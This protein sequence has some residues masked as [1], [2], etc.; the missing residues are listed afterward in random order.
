MPNAMNYRN[1]PRSLA[2]TLILGLLGALSLCQTGCTQKAQDKASSQVPAISGLTFEDLATPTTAWVSKGGASAWTMTANASTT[3]LMANFGTTGGGAVLSPGN[4][5]IVSGVPVHVAPATTTTYTLT[6]TDAAG[7]TATQ[8]AILTVVPSPNATIT[9][10]ATAIANTA[11]LAASVSSD[12]AVNAPGTTYQ[13]AALGNCVI[14]SD[15]TSPAITFTAGSANAD[16]SAQNLQLQCKVTNPA[17]TPVVDTQ[18]VTIPVNAV[19][20]ASLSYPSATLTFYQG[21]AIQ[22]QSPTVTGAVQTYKVSPALPA[23]LILDPALGTLTG[24][25]TTVTPAANY[26]VTATNSGGSTTAVLNI[27]V[28]AQPAIVFNTPTPAKIGPGDTSIL[29]WTSGSN[30]S[31][32]SIVGNPVDATLPATFPIT[33]SANVSPAQTTTY[34]LTATLVGGGTLSGGTQTVTVDKTPLAFTTQLSATSGVVAYGGTSTLNWVLTGTPDVFTLTS[35]ATAGSVSLLGSTSYTAFPLRRQNYT[36][37]ASNKVPSSAT[38]GPVMVA[39]Q[40]LDTLAGNITLG[41]GSHDGTGTAAQFNAPYN[42]ARDPA[43]NIYVPD[44]NNHIIRVVTPQGAVSTLAG[45]CGVP[46]VTD[47]VSGLQAQFKGPHA[48]A[49]WV[50]PS[51]SQPYL[52]VV[53]YTNNSIRKITLNTGTTP[54]TATNVSLFAGTMGSYGTSGNFFD[55]PSGILI[56]SSNNMYVSEQY[57][58]DVLKITGLSGAQGNTYLQNGG[59]LT[60]Y[61]GSRGNDGYVDGPNASAYFYQISSMVMDS[62]NNIYVAESKANRIRMISPT[63]TSTLAGDTAQLGLV[64][65]SSTKPVIQGAAGFVDGKAGTSRLN[66][67]GGLAL[68]GG[69]LYVA[70]TSNNAVRALNLSTGNLTTVLGSPTT[71]TATPGA[72]GSLNGQGTS[73]TLAGPQGLL[74]D[75]SGNFYISELGNN[76]IR[77]ADTSLNVT[78]FVGS[79]A[80]VG[81]ADGAPGVGTMAINPA[82]SANKT[83]AC[84]V[85]NAAGNLFVADVYNNAIR[86]IT[87]AGV[88]STIAGT[89]GLGTAGSL[90]GTGASASFNQPNG[91]A[92]DGSGNLYVAD[93]NNS[94]IRMMVWDSTNKVWNVSTIAGKAGVTG[95]ADGALGTSTFKFPYGITFNAKDGCLY[96]ADSG[97]SKIRK[98]TNT[99]GAW[100]V[101]SLAPTV[102][103]LATP[104]GIA[105]DAAGNLYFS[106]RGKYYVGLLT[107]PAWAG[108]VIGGLSGTYGFANGAVGT[109]K[110]ASSLFN[111][112]QGVSVDA[113]GNVW[114]ADL[115]NNTVGKIANVGGVW[116]TTTVVGQCAP[117]N[118]PPLQAVPAGT[119]VGPFPATLFMPQSVLVSPSGPDLYITTNGGVAQATSIDGQ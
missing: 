111:Y 43:G 45:I 23:G 101:S 20:P 75:A 89:A 84:M 63:T 74:F 7:H 8:N 46:G 30:V 55:S 52:F 99:A 44:A 48:V 94:T 32:I 68:S 35:P 56:D 79:A 115:G 40:G 86:M 41:G 34:T 92:I 58:G 116:T 25:P 13:W 19:P 49:Y 118:S 28:D 66:A 26:T 95:A 42:I 51:T 100:T 119:S 117:S 31:A 2:T 90:D 103:T 10:P 70:D 54:P 33:G 72:A 113:N 27:A 67:P 29:S 102:V 109:T 4:L 112:P 59:A 22:K 69:T 39:A 104:M 87:P 81:S 93:T 12:P 76:D 85:L 107:A 6:V 36:L 65:N 61:A 17:N 3:Y 38:S 11:G 64:Y 18:T 106:D 37:T 96:V 24:T 91:L 1:R 5:S 105:A 97:N 9:A 16:G 114:V 71:G 110:T 21:L 50:D 73:A 62:S 78:N 82:L 14:T 53:E 77:K 15:A 47:G 60:V 83:M 57:Y 88:L 108:T 80:L 98:L